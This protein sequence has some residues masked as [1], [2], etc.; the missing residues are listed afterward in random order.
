MGKIKYQKCDCC[1]KE[2]PKN[3]TYFKKYSHKTANGLNFHTICRSCEEKLEYDIEWEDGKLLCH[4]CGQ[5]LDSDHFNL[6]GGN[7]YNIRNGRDKR[8]SRCKLEQNKQARE[9]YPEYAKLQK[10]LQE[11]WLGAKDRA[12]A[13][14]IPFT[15]TKEDLLELWE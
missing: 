12:A 6:A 15:I 11:R 2:F 5:Y 10:V 1:G 4:V 7:K 8:C 3:I 13:K 9:N 14:G